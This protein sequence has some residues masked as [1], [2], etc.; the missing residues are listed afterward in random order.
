VGKP[1]IY[2]SHGTRDQVLPIDACS[3]RL[4]PQL[5]RTGYDVRF[6]EFDG[7]HAIPAEIAQEALDWFVAGR[8]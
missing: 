6:H 1:R 3:R 4:V 8:D 5:E 7:P 2:V